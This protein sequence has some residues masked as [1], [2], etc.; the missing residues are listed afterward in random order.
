MTFAFPA[1]PTTIDVEGFHV[2][3]SDYNHTAFTYGA[4]FAVLWHVDTLAAPVNVV[5]RMIGEF[6]AQ[7]PRNRIGLL[8]VVEANGNLPPADARAALS[9][10]LQ[11]NSPWLIRSAVAFEGSGFKAAAVRGAATGIALLSRQN[12]P[13]RIFGGVS[14]ATAWLAEGLAAEL[15]ISANGEELAAVI[16]QVR[17]LR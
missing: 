16:A 3:A 9:R 10:L 7:Q 8:G 14:A 11:V 13:H 12:F 4:L 15:G 17:A 6:A 2:L 5:S 1:D